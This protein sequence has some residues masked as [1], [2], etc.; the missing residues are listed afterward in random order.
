MTELLAAD[1]LGAGLSLGG[2]AALLGGPARWG[3][4]LAAI[5]LGEAGRLGMALLLDGRPHIWTFGGAFTR[6]QGGGPYELL[7]TLAGPVLG[8]LAGFAWSRRAG[9]DTAVYAI[10]GALVRVWLVE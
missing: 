4:A 2:L 8:A 5:L 9:W 7:V 6:L 1:W 3:R 10:C